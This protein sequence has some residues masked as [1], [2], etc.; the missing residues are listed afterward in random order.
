MLLSLYPIVEVQV[1][2]PAES[3][4]APALA[5]CCVHLTLFRRGPASISCLYFMCPFVVTGNDHT[6]KTDCK[7]QS[8]NHSTLYVSLLFQSWHAETFGGTEITDV[9]NTV[10]DSVSPAAGYW[11]VE[12]KV[13]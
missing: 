8:S 3:L 5:Q 11:P 1:F 9:A 4:T 2:T 13:I 6:V 10:A 7:S 12:T